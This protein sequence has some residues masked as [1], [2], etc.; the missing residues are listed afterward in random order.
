MT[1][2]TPA[3]GGAEEV[4]A[5]MVTDEDAVPMETVITGISDDKYG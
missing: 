2:R 1:A 5:E 3:V 4:G